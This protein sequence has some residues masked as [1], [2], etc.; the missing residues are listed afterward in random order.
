MATLVS[1]F[2][3]L[4]ETLGRHFWELGVVLLEDLVRYFGSFG[5]VLLGA[6]MGYFWEL[7]RDTFKNIEEVLLGT[8]G[9]FDAL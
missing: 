1:H 6:L 5:E 2:C 4:T 9:K 8:F 7:L 3:K